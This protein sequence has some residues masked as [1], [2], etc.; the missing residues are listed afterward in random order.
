[1]F[2]NNAAVLKET[3]VTHGL[4]SK[5][6]ITVKKGFG[7]KWSFSLK[8]PEINSQLRSLV[9]YTNYGREA[10]NA[11]EEYNPVVS[12][13]TKLFFSN[14]NTT[15]DA[16][17]A[18]TFLDK[19]V[20]VGG[21]EENLLMAQSRLMAI[22]AAA[23]YRVQKT[24]TRDLLA[25]RC[26]KLMTNESVIM[27]LLGGVVEAFAKG[28]LGYYRLG[29]DD[30]MDE[31]LTADFVRM[32]TTLPWS[33]YT[34]D[35]NV[36]HLP[37]E[38]AAAADT[39]ETTLSVTITK[40]GDGGN[41]QG[42]AGGNSN[43][44]GGTHSGS[45]NDGNK[46]VAAGTVTD[47]G[48]MGDDHWAAGINAIS[49]TPKVTVGPHPEFEN[50]E[51]MFQLEVGKDPVPA[52][53]F[54]KPGSRTAI[55]LSR[56]NRSVAPFTGNVAV[57]PD[58]PGKVHDLF[59]LLGREV[60]E[61]HLFRLCQ[62]VSH[63]GDEAVIDF[64]LKTW[65]EI[66]YSHSTDSFDATYDVHAKDAEVMIDSMYSVV[67]HFR[68]AMIAKEETDDGYMVHEAYCRPRGT[69]L[70]IPEWFKRQL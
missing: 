41:G 9:F 30:V 20:I 28:H 57:P 35:S 4:L 7:A 67:E 70:Q 23:L 34:T 47:L 24:W 52:S 21:S 43:S 5:K 22:V 69:K 39:E 8:K 65:P 38:T 56:I 19:K 16:V 66:D 26:A 17:K 51:P 11:L 1:M 29:I 25:T 18:I 61:N 12:S 40:E 46:Q 3:A 6:T 15:K 53:V 10:Y 68:L 48:V 63:R 45:G 42:G 55:S 54:L 33:D 2:G 44:G 32:L 64:G 36:Y 50:K 49:I 14:I 13:V 60:S 27:G 59:R 62:E 58:L 31:Q 37:T